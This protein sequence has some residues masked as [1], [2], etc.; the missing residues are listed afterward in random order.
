[1]KEEVVNVTYDILNDVAQK[2]N[3]TYGDRAEVYYMMNYRGGP[4]DLNVLFD[5]IYAS[6]NIID[7]QDISIEIDIFNTGDPIRSTRF[8]DELGSFLTDRLVAVEGEFDIKFKLRNP[9]NSQKTVAANRN[10]TIDAQIHRLAA[11]VP[12]VLTYNNIDDMPDLIQITNYTR[13]K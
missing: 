6:S 7:Q 8:L 11:S 2:Y 10:T 4:V 13:R 3:A 9:I 5:I 1:M 12:A